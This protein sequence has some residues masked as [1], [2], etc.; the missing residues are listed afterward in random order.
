M[1][2]AKGVAQALLSLGA[3]VVEVD[4]TAR[5]F[6]LPAGAGAAFNVIHGTFGED[7]SLQALLEQRRIPYTGAG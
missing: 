1:E 3:E 7:G 5:D 4:V 2:T 6:E